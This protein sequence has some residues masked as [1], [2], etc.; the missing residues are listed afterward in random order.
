MVQ[1][2]IPQELEKRSDQ[3]ARKYAESYSEEI[4]AELEELSRQIAEMNKALICQ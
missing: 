4:R 2:Q 1:D 3:L